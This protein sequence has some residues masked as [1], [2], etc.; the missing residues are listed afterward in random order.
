[1]QRISIVFAL[2][3]TIM[4][5]ATTVQAELR[6]PLIGHVDGLNLKAKVIV[7]DD[8][9]FRL[10]PNYMVKSK[11]GKSISAFR[12]KKGNM[13]DFEVADD[14]LVHEIVIKR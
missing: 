14:G 12:L 10:A 9:V 4:C 6:K 5:S 11:S 13:V 7:V 8:M 2:L 1:M 3:L